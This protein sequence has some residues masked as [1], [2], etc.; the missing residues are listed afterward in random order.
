MKKIR[1]AIAV[2]IV[3]LSVWY[4]FI[5]SND[6][7]I[8]FKSNTSP[9]IVFK[10]VEEWNLLNQK[11][12]SF[13]YTLIE[14]KPFEFFSESITTKKIGLKVNWN[15]ESIN[16]STT[17]VKVGLSE[18][19]NSIYNRLTA[20]FIK[21]L[22]KTESINLIQDFKDGMDYQ[23][24]NKYKVKVVG[25]DAVPEMSYAY[26]ELKNIALSEKAAEMLKNNATLIT[27]V[28]E[29]NL[30]KGDF[31]FIRI[32]NWDIENHLIDFRYCFPIVETDSL[33]FDESIKY[34]KL[35]STSAIKAVYNGNYR[36]SD[37]GWLGLYDYAIKHHIETSNHPIEFF[38]NNPFYG[39]DELKWVTEIYMPVKE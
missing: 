21:T 15:F 22:F 23:L 4:L 33:P 7:I 30:K 8:T 3:G 13:N 31:P 27:F 29:H 39:G 5:K 34:D 24:K 26:I 10:E 25:Q 11:V 32:E 18:H 2:I 19:E 17:L 28:T 9:G 36:T 37:R 6:Y 14:K 1:Y 35:K 16:D 12:D 38:F 20:P